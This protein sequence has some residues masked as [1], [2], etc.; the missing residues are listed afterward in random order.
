MISFTLPPKGV[1]EVLG[2]VFNYSR[3]LSGS[4]TLTAASVTAVLY[5]GTDT[6][7][8]AIISGTPMITSPQA[9]Q[10]VTGGLV[11][12]IYQLT[13]MATSSFG[14]TYAQTTLLSVVPDPSP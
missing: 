12:N 11:G 7:P 10:T 4:E 14:Y 8:S 13:C 3:V 1:S 2:V 9:T 6:N 5:S